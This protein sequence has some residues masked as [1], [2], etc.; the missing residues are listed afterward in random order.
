VNTLGKFVKSV[1]AF[2]DVLSR[3]VV[4]PA[5]FHTPRVGLAL[6]GGFAR[7]LAHIGVLKVLEEE[8]IPVDCVAGTSVGA[9]IGAMYCSG[10]SAKR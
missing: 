3:P 10:V 4:A 8:G 5:E 6:G 9:I 2:G 1:R 7:A